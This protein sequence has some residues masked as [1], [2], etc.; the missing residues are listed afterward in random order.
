MIT[1]VVVVVVNNGS[2]QWMGE[3]RGVTA[4]DGIPWG[5]DVKNHNVNALTAKLTSLSS[6]DRMKAPTYRR[7][8]M[9]TQDNFQCAYRI[10]KRAHT[11]SLSITNLISTDSASVIY[12]HAETSGR[13]SELHSKAAQKISDFR[14]QNKYA[15]RICCSWSSPPSVLSL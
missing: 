11:S 8:E 6:S 1:V 9:T 10:L 3:V 4:T 2:V 5:S 15:V 14:P 7:N 13:L 12:D